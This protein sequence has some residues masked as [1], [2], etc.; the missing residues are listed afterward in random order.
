MNAQLPLV[1][2][3]VREEI[4]RHLGPVSCTRPGPFG[5]NQA[6]PGSA[7]PGASRSA[8]KATVALLRAEVHLRGL[9][10]HLV[11]GRLLF[12]PVSLLVRQQIGCPD[13][14]MVSNSTIRDRHLIQ[15]AY[16][17]GPRHVEQF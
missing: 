17:E 8:T 4:A 16:Q 12:S 5:G 1:E 11:D 3:L 10:V 2:R 7:R 13:T 14:A 15:Q 6:L 9:A